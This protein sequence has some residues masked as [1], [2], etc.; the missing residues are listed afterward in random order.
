MENCLQMTTPYQVTL[1]RKVNEI[2]EVNDNDVPFCRT[3][4]IKEIQFI[5]ESPAE[6]KSSIIEVD[7]YFTSVV[8]ITRDL[9]Y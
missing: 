3:F 4:P 2:D 9:Y 7:Y 6:L 8:Q 1:P 5:P